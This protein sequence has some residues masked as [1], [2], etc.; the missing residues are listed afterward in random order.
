M[1]LHDEAIILSTQAFQDTKL[2]VK[3]LSKDHG[4]I[5]GIVRA[6]RTNRTHIQLGNH[7]QFTWSARL[8]SHLGQ[9]ELDLAT[10]YYGRFFH[11]PYKLQLMQLALSM[12]QL[13]LPERL[14]AKK[15]YQLCHNFLGQPEEWQTYYVPL[16]QAVLIEAGFP[17]HWSRCYK[18]NHCDAPH[19]VSPKTGNA[20]CIEH[21]KGYEDK[22]L[23]LPATQKP[24][25]QEFAVLYHYFLDKWVLSERNYD[26]L[27]TYQ[28]LEKRLIDK[29]NEVRHHEKI[30]A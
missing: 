11:Q 15:L 28:S 8:E 12:V 13:A 1:Q 3:L 29:Q 20:V 2:L 22:C 24:H 9:L 7:V 19:Y 17:T 30:T 27:H 18:G 23:K 14:P 25:V 16:L 10:A 26:T 6:N 21:A 5:A 4:V